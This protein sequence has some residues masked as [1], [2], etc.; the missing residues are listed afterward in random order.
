MCALKRN[1]EEV[2]NPISQL[3][4]KEL[5]NSLPHDMR[6]RYIIQLSADYVSVR[7]MLDNDTKQG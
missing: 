1:G 3:A 2:V 7:N 5:L 6:Q 4:D